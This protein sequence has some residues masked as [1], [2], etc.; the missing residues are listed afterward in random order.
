MGGP[1]VR[2]V[3]TAP[4]AL[5]KPDT[6]IPTL[7]RDERPLAEWLAYMAQLCRDEECAP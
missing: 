7:V 3:V 2:D 1:L 5:Q 4:P 6:T